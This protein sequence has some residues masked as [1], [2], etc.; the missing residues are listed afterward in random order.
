MIIILH[1]MQYAAL[2]LFCSVL[3]RKSDWPSFLGKSSFEP[4]AAAW[5]FFFRTYFTMTLFFGSSGL[6]WFFSASAPSAVTLSS[7]TSESQLSPSLLTIA[8]VVGAG[9]SIHP[10]IGRPVFKHTQS[11]DFVFQTS[12]RMLWIIMSEWI[13]ILLT[14]VKA[15]D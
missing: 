9:T 12:L 1:T 11:H 2:Q 3:A 7:S 10:L 5:G 4:G 15:I 14:A 13:G 8:A 6:M